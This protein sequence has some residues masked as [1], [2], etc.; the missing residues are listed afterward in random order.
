MNEE[1]IAA[2][3]QNQNLF[4]DLSEKGKKAET[5]LKNQQATSTSLL[6]LNLEKEVISSNTLGQHIASINLEKFNEQQEK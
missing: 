1:A 5:L 3:G 2:I 6:K 4:K